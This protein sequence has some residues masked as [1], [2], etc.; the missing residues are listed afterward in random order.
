MEPTYARRAFP[1]F[2]EPALK[3]SFNITLIADANLTCLSNMHISAVE[4]IS[5][6][7]TNK[8]AIKFHQTPVMSTYLVAFAVGEL[9]YIENNESRIPIRIYV[10]PENDAEHGIYA[11]HI[12]AKSLAFYEDLF[13]V[14]YPLPKLDVFAPPVF[15]GAM[16][17]WGLI[18]G[19]AS[20]LMYDTK[21]DGIHKKQ[22]VAEM[23]MHE[24]AHQW[25]G[26]LVTLDWWDQTWLNEGG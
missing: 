3:A 15:M 18:I 25:F 2:D 9:S 16:E 17:N 10:S 23:V 21:R 11:A 20:D 13:D 19:I 22:R 1:C 14:P 8:K 7:G 26:N 4:D 5:T 6:A 24:L 12:L